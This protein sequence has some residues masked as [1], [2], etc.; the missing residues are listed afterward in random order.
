MS[1]TK[2]RGR[3]RAPLLDRARD[4]SNVRGHHRRDVADVVERDLIGVKRRRDDADVGQIIL[5]GIEYPAGRLFST[6]S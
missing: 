3:S 6:K 2:P 1:G 4:Q 5:Q